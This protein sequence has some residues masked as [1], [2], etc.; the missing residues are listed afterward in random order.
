MQLGSWSVTYDQGLLQAL[1]NHRARHLPNETGG[2]LLGIIDVSRHSIHVAHAMPQPEDSRGSTAGFERGIVGLL[3][4]LT[5]VAQASLHQLRYVGEWHS[6]PAG[7]SVWPSQVDI[8]QL[9]WLGSE[10]EAEGVPALMSIAGADGT[11]SVMLLDD[12][13][14]EKAS[15]P[16][17]GGQVS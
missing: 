15:V 14:D 13:R 5:D 8:D 3:D 2:A 7:S 9:A 17:Q 1:G 12:A 11:F 4:I 6:H 10:L 16:K